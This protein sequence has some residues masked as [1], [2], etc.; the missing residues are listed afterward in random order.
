MGE[1]KQ[2]GWVSIDNALTGEEIFVVPTGKMALLFQVLIESGNVGKMGKKELSV[3]VFLQSL[4]SALVW[5]KRQPKSGKGKDKEVTEE[6][7]D[8]AINALE[9]TIASVVVINDE[10][11]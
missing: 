6:T 2:M 5:L 11:L 8:R 1:M 7:L 9:R 3:P 10:N 4:R